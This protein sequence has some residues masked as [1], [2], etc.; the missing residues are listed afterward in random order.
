MKRN[1]VEHNSDEERTV[2]LRIAGYPVSISF[3][4]EADATVV[5]R[6]RNCLIDSYIRNKM[7]KCGA[8]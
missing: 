8:A 6:V 1:K 7:E 2:E 3:A 5:Q 4:A